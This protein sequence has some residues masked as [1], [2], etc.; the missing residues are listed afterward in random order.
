MNI[1]LL[2]EQVDDSSADE[3]H[4]AARI[5]AVDSGIIAWLEQR[6]RLG[7]DLFLHVTAYRRVLWRLEGTLRCP[8]D[9]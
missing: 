3:R 4:P 9:P 7:F 8:K 6:E 2:K 1:E 5:V